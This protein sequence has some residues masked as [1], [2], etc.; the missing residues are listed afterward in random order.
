[1]GQVLHQVRCRLYLKQML[2]LLIKASTPNL[3][4]LW[5][6]RQLLR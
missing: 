4:L 1:L 2:W 5:L 3:L 6:H